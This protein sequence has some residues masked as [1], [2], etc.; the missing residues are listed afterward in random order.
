MIVGLSLLLVPPWLRAFAGTAACARG[1]AGIGTTILRRMLYSFRRS[2]SCRGLVG[3]FAETVLRSGATLV[4][5]VPEGR[6]SSGD[7]RK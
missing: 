3:L 2:R 6:C 4:R 5:V 7:T 1:A